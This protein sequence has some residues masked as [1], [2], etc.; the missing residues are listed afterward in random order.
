MSVYVN[1]P[2]VTVRLE[3][4]NGSVISTMNPGNGLIADLAPGT[5]YIRTTTYTGLLDSGADGIS[6]QMEQTGIRIG[7]SNMY[8]KTI[9]TNPYSDDTDGDGITDG[10]EMFELKLYNSS[11]NFYDV[12]DDPSNPTIGSLASTSFELPSGYDWNTTDVATIRSNILV[13]EA[14]KERLISYYTNVSNSTSLL[15]P[16]RNNEL[17]YM[18]TMIGNAITGLNSDIGSMIEDVRISGTDSDRAWLASQTNNI[19]YLSYESSD[20]EMVGIASGVGVAE[21]YDF[22]YWMRIGT[23]THTAIANK[24]ISEVGPAGQFSN[25]EIPFIPEKLRP[26]LVYDENRAINQSITSDGLAH[27]FEVKTQNNTPAN[28][29]YYQAAQRQLNNYIVKYKQG[30]PAKTVKKGTTGIS[31]GKPPIWSPDGKYVDIPNTP[32]GAILFHVM[33]DDGMV[34]YKLIRKTQNS[35]IDSAIRI[36]QNNARKQYDVKVGSETVKVTTVAKEKK[37]G[38]IAAIGML[39]GALVV[40]VLVAADDATGVGVAD[41][42]AGI[43]VAGRLVSSAITAW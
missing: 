32:F 4:G 27:L 19:E 9:T 43:A 8:V 14:H 20:P 42:P 34:Y 22:K 26:D 28:W 2:L 10:T 11:N 16:V 21:T 36:I 12:I 38:K 31:E 37:S 17:S 1:V 7:Y 5:Y 29:P 39:A 3:D 35:K 30:F 25:R 15:S 13:A 41:D 40:I 18:A 24:F 6:D 23:L 33:P